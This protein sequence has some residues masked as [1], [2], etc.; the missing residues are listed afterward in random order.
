[1]FVGRS[2]R[3]AYTIFIAAAPLIFTV[4]FC[5]V[6][7]IK[8]MTVDLGNVMLGSEAGWFGVM[9]R[10]EL[11]SGIMV[12][13][14]VVIGLATVLFLCS[15]AVAEKQRRTAAR[16]GKCAVCG[17][18]LRASRER[19]PECGTPFRSPVRSGSVVK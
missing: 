16:A 19:C 4:T 5:A 3:T 1:M 2:R 15:I 17:Y 10:D 12:S 6:S 8:P 18:D 9:V 11:P 13:Y 14:W 7:Y